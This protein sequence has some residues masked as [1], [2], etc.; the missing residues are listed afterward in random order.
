[1]VRP[2][3]HEFL[4]ETWVLIPT[5]AFSYRSHLALVDSDLFPYN[6]FMSYPVH[7]QP[8]SPGCNLSMSLT[9]EHRRSKRIVT[10]KRA[11]LLVNFK[12]R[13]ERLPCLVVDRSQD[14]FRPRVSSR[15]KRG[16]VVEVILDE[17]PSDSLRCSVIWVGK[18]GSKQQG[19]V[20]LQVM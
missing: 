14:G 16:Q 13:V 6:F 2:K 8:S 15:L 5:W 11:S 18:P 4:P 20:G 19:E 3:A 1:M 9:P 12:G 7:L 10:K 17:N